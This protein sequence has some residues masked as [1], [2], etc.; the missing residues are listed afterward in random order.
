MLV[1]CV[2]FELT[3]MLLFRILEIEVLIWLRLLF[4]DL[5]LSLLLKF[6]ELLERARVR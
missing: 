2:L 1:R 6:L 4:D 3:L 5:D